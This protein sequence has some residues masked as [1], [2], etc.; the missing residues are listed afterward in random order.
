MLARV[1]SNT[2]YMQPVRLDDAFISLTIKHIP[3]RW[4]VLGQQ[5]RQLTVASCLGYFVVGGSKPGIHIG[6]NVLA[7]FQL[8]SMSAAPY[9]GGLDAQ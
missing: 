5:K 7:V 2:L 6:V 1:I 3:L 9:G 4:L 8:D